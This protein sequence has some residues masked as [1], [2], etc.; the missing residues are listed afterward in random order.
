[1]E[2]LSSNDESIL[3]SKDE[4]QS[5]WR[6]LEQSTHRTGE[7]PSKNW[8]STTASFLWLESASAAVTTSVVR[9]G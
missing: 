1:V 2:V 6:L 8:C 4:S 3:S 5:F 7:H 9:L